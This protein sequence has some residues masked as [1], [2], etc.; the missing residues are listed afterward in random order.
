MI[1]HG[2]IRYDECLIS[3][4]RLVFKQIHF[5]K[6]FQL[7]FPYLLRNRSTKT[8]GLLTLLVVSCEIIATTLC[9]LLI[10]KICNT[11]D[12]DGGFSVAFGLT[13]LFSFLWM[14]EKVAMDIE[15]VIFFPVINEAIK[16]ITSNTVGHLH[17]ISL[18]D[19]VYS[20]SQIISMIK[21]ISLSA[22]SFIRVFFLL[23]PRTLLKLILVCV[24]LINY[25]YYGL[26]ILLGVAVSF[27]V[28]YRCLVWYVQKRS[29]AWAC[30]DRVT[31]ALH[32][33]ILFTKTARYHEQFE[34]SRLQ[35]SLSE[36][37]ELW[38]KT[39]TRLHLTSSFVSLVFGL[40]YAAV[41]ALVVFQGSSIGDFIFIKGLVLS[42]FLPLRSMTR[43]IRMTAESII[44]IQKIIEVLAIPI[45]PKKENMDSVQ[46]KAL[47]EV[48]NLSFSYSNE[49]SFL[50]SV[51]LQFDKGDTVFI[52]GSSGSG[53]STFC[54]LL[55]GLISPK[56]G[57]IY[58]KG[59]SLSSSTKEEL[60][61]SLLFISQQAHILN[62]TIY[63]NLTY[64]MEGISK[65][66][67]DHVVESVGLDQLIDKS[68]EGLSTIIGE[69][70]ACISGGERQK[71]ALAR[72]L[73]AEPEILI[74]DEAI[75]SLDAASAHHILKQL[76]KK[77]PT[78]FL[79]SHQMQYVK[80]FN[81]HLIFTAGSINHIK[82]SFEPLL[83]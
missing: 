71:I 27:L 7:F 34:M 46:T 54:H 10:K 30:T 44:D 42:V 4:N 66:Y 20:S 25:Q 37:A 79:V 56:K 58:L 18:Q 35:K 14:I 55:S 50:E 26:S 6:V 52:S 9:P 22:R 21:R 5:K 49:V 53:K 2:F 1:F 43:Q 19:Q 41:L 12:L 59:R 77:V 24:I 73:L 16:D 45:S 29:E 40:S 11:V 75:E 8:R 48:K 76:K 80:D 3:T 28:L 23:L 32:E 68:I 81:N 72:A 39:N 15:E 38:N 51:T 47:L 67:L 31:Q 60:G 78:I 69:K 82:A 74:L 83:N 33:S 64:G 63:E 61:K 62:A 13:L 70:G 36:E 65:S 57:E 17:K